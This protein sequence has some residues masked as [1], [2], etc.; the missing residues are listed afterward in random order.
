MG[1]VTSPS[2]PLALDLSPLLLGGRRV[3][4]ILQGDSVPRI[5]IPWLIDLYR[6]GR[7]P[8][9]RIIQ[10][11]PFARIAEAMHDSEAGRAVKPVLT[12]AA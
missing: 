9:E 1:F 6:Q 10:L 11:Y 7:F 12:M 4:G 2:G 3:Q 5:F 8:L